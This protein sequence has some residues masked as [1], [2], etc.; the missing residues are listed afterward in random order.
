M[1]LRVLRAQLTVEAGVADIL[2]RFEWSFYH[3]MAVAI[4]HGDRHTMP[5]GHESVQ[6]EL[7]VGALTRSLLPPAVNKDVR[8]I[9]QHKMSE[10]KM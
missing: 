9:A 10:I 1:T 2:S 3:R 7:K 5:C 6:N 8:L 4:R